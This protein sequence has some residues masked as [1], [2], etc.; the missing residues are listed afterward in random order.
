MI[1]WSKLKD[2]VEQVAGS[3]DD[4]ER[5]L[6]GEQL[7]LA[8]AALLVRACVIDGR[9][10]AK[11]RETVQNLLQSRYELAA[12]EAAALLAAAEA[13]ERQ[14]VDLYGFTSVLTRQL[15]QEGR[16]RVIEMLWEAVMTDGRVH[17]FE[18][19]LVW[20][21]SELLGVSAR[22]RIALR[23]QVAGRQAGAETT[24]N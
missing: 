8:T 22:D 3:D 23:K 16:K 10:D 20:R 11:E 13:K 17:E 9:I 19:N 1:L 18:G 6:D 5:E 24:R 14:A 21:V 12:S 4:D 2:F 7:R 15:D